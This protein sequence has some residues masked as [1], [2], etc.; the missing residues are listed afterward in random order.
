MCHALIVL[1]TPRRSLGAAL[2]YTYKKGTKE[3]NAYKKRT[4]RHAKETCL[5]KKRPVHV[6][7]DRFELKDTFLRK[8]RPIYVEKGPICVKRDLFT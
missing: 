7:K 3:T 5:R 1:R 6:N 4:K 2:W 8:K